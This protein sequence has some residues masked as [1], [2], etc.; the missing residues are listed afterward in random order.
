MASFKV[1]FRIGTE[2]KI[3][4]EFL[5]PVS[6]TKL[7]DLHWHYVQFSRRKEDFTL[8]VDGKTTSFRAEQPANGEF[9]KLDEGAFLGGPGGHKVTDLGHIPNFRG[10]LGHV[11]L[12]GYKVLQLTVAFQ[13]QTL[14]YRTDRN[15]SSLFKADQSSAPVSFVASGA[16]MGF[17]LAEPQTSMVLYF[18]IRTKTTNSALL[19]SSGNPYSN[20]FLLL[21]L[22]DSRLY[23][24]ISH[25]KGIL[26]GHSKK[27]VSDGR[28]HR[29]SIKLAD[30]E[31]D[32]SVDETNE[33]LFD[34]SVKISI[35]LGRYL[36]FGGSEIYS[37]QELAN[38]KS[39]GSQGFLGCLHNIVH[40]YKPLGLKQ[41][42]VSMGIQPGCLYQ[43]P[44][45]E[46]P[47]S[48]E[49][50]C[51]EFG[52][53]DFQCQCGNNNADSCSDKMSADSTRSPIST[54]FS[55][56]PERSGKI[57]QPLD[58]NPLDVIEGGT[59][60][61]D[62]RNLYIF[63]QFRR[64][65]L[66]NKDIRFWVAEPPEHGKLTRSEEGSHVHL[67]S[68]QDVLD[69][70]LNYTHDSSETT[71]DSVE[72]EVEFFNYSAEFFPK[73]LQKRLPYTLPIHIRPLNDPPKIQLL[74]GRTLRLAHGSKLDITQE[75][76][77]VLDPDTLPSRVKVKILFATPNS[78][79]FEL[80][81]APGVPLSM[82]SLEN[83][84]NGQI[85]YVQ[86][87]QLNAEV[88]LMA[89][90]EIS[91]S[92]PVTLHVDAFHIQ[93]RQVVNTGLRVLHGS[94][95][96][97]TN[98]NLSFST[99]APSQ[100]LDIQYKIVNIPRRG[101]VEVQQSNGD[102]QVTETFN[103]SQIDRGAIR[104]RHVRENRPTDDLFKFT[105]TV[106]DFTALNVF[107]FRVSFMPVSL[108]ILQQSFVLNNTREKTI[109]R[110][111]LFTWTYPKMT[112]P[113]ETIYH[114]TAPPR[115][116]YLFK[117]LEEVGSAGRHRRIGLFSNFTQ[118]DVNRELIY[119]KLHYANHKMLRDLF[120]F[121]VITPSVTGTNN[122]FAITY[123]PGDGSI[124]LTNRSVLVKEGS[125]Q[126]ITV[127]H[128]FLETRDHKDFTFFVLIPP[129]H[130]DL[131]LLVAPNS[132]K[133]LG[134]G[135]SFTT[136]DI[137]ND[138]LFY[139]HD[140]S[141]SV[142]DKTLL[143]AKPRNTVNNQVE[144]Q[145]WLTFKVLLLDDNEPKRVNYG[146]KPPVFY[147]I[148]SSERLVRQRDLH[149]ADADTDSKAESI[150]FTFPPSDPNGGFYSARLPDIPVN[151]FTQK[152]I[153]NDEILFRHFGVH[154]SFGIP[155]TVSDGKFVIRDNFTV[156][157]SRPFLREF[158]NSGLKLEHGRTVAIRNVNLSM[159]TNL[160]AK[161]EEIVYKLTS[162]PQYGQINVQSVSSM[163]K[164][165]KKSVE[166]FTQE[167]VDAGRV[168]YEHTSTDRTT[169]KDV[170]YLSVHTGDLERTVEFVIVISNETVLRVAANKEVIVSEGGV[171]VISKDNL[172]MI[173]PQFTP[174]SIVYTVVESPIYG[175]LILEANRR[176]MGKEVV[177]IKDFYV[178]KFTQFD[179]NAGNLQYM[180]GNLNQ[181]T[182]RIVMNV[183]AGS[184]QVNYVK[185]LIRVV[186][187]EIFLETRNFTV[188]SER[189]FQLDST[190]ISARCSYY[191]NYSFVF[192]VTDPPKHGWIENRTDMNNIQEVETFT[193]KDLQS[194]TIFYT[195][196]GK[197]FWGDQFSVVAGLVG[198]NLE[199]QP[200]SVHIRIQH[201]N[202]EGNR[203]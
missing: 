169:L 180:H 117:V 66:S 106:L 102:W 92:D 194:G 56:L 90:D 35:F 158:E 199:S 129:S 170:L 195:N 53:S 31:F 142:D 12:N 111:Y 54:S 28:W 202:I 167:D 139:K 6:L 39:E 175:S 200:K 153:D 86:T 136:D 50:E 72:L 118:A 160:D 109:T 34:S 91:D 1:S 55:R 46:S 11:K 71:R 82:F 138:R 13:S 171:T 69:G 37:T 4:T 17:T 181:K 77:L 189:S 193:T 187:N 144:I 8:T 113:D 74:N 99:N 172:E 164:S 152:Q 135:T 81:S 47:C 24:V 176:T 9:F 97:I 101:F 42:D 7:N 154:K 145:F 61:L 43:Y 185:L 104:F 151:I 121:K 45:S 161:P 165:G 10:C 83:L 131:K 96:L 58:V 68:Y 40:Q 49:F 198:E 75:L 163:E 146:R 23:V 173:H 78:G 134:N 73:D 157:G 85:V 57:T 124:Q 52:F 20:H 126:P 98:A 191:Q 141:E 67:F 196:D 64:F 110:E 95:E 88:I 89:S 120:Q 122:P 19:Y 108:R 94:H 182:D 192:T 70:R 29:V 62:W 16:F 80:K 201:L 87:G 41:I 123:L 190:H 197:M 5:S 65:G 63:P 36:N 130:G 100:K 137:A 155:F 79:Y 51:V 128:L 119:Y 178:H 179:V 32:L 84:I 143:S 107:E 168:F 2:Y 38:A 76:I 177:D 21:K 125:L 183:S 112:P 166:F 159:E 60:R 150:V 140:D 59:Q 15:C 25:V 115:S 3:A 132:K 186:K 30:E 188:F 156:N 127:Q 44:C 203:S 26:A 162:L 133:T 148:S 114:I 116:G 22:V 93:L 149:Y 14:S 27:V 48:P 147:V 105:A 174:A 33:K 103:Q 18:E 184:I